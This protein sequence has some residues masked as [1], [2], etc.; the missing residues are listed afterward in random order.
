VRGLRRTA[1][2]V[3]VA[4]AAQPAPT[5]TP[6]ESGTRALLI[7]VSAVS[8]R[9]AWVSGSRGTWRRTIDGGETW[10]GGTVPGADSVQFRDVHALDERT[11]WLLSIG[12]GPASRIY[13]TDD[14]GAT[15]T[16]QFRNEDQRRFYDCFAFWDAQRAIV[17]GDAVGTEMDVLRTTDGGAHWER[18]PAASL[19]RA[20][21]GEG[22]F[23]ASGTC[24]ATGPGGRAWIVMS[25]PARA[26]LLR[27]S[28][29]GR[30]WSLET[31]PITTH[32]GS[33]PQSVA[34]RDERYGMVLA[35]GDASTKDDT[36]IAITDDGGATWTPRRS[37]DFR[38]GTWGGAW[39]HGAPTPTIVAVGPGGS[40]FSRDL[41]ASWSPID[42]GNY[43][44]V[45]FAPSRT[46]WAVGTQGRITRLGGW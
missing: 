41:G 45:G 38:S 33:G 44:S 20:E 46:G 1:A 21:E 4:F 10:T 19:P 12:N 3:V 23:A 27:T 13:R 8:D 35:G 34:F 30:S 37:P 42:S 29:Y 14:G 16:Q 22:S 18:I 25:T 39:V 36:L 11:A 32:A 28:D 6:Q 31:L 2:L 43:W 15:W 24:A 5:V 7:A 26:R 17:I 40:A 9:V